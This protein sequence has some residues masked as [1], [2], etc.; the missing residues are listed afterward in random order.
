MSNQAQRSFYQGYYLLSC[1]RDGEPGV[2]PPG[3]D[4]P[5]PEGGLAAEKKNGMGAENELVL[6]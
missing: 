1:P 6:A 4:C 5:L 3:G 2:S